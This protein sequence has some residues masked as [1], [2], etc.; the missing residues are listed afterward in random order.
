MSSDED[1]EDDDVVNLMDSGERGELDLQ[2][3]IAITLSTAAAAAAADDDDDDGSSSS[4]GG[5]QTTAPTQT[6]PQPHPSATNSRAITADYRGRDTDDTDDDRGSPS[7]VPD[8]SLSRVSSTASTTTTKSN[9]NTAVIPSAPVSVDLSQNFEL[10]LSTNEQLYHL[11]KDSHMANERL[12][13]RVHELERANKALVAAQKAGLAS[14]LGVGG[15][16]GGG[17]M[18]TPGSYGAAGASPGGGGVGGS[19]GVTLS[20]LVAERDAA[21]SEMEV[22]QARA[23]DAEKNADNMVDAMRQ[24]VRNFLKPDLY[25]P[26]YYSDLLL[27]RTPLTHSFLFF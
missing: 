8:P 7:P 16:D 17:S 13:A 15:S 9:T 18:A 6:P 4:S 12:T 22:L 14:T 2:G 11:L 24:A 20:T 19:S 27:N 23:R 21:L 25:T 3:R 10:S 5:E 1:F 26:R